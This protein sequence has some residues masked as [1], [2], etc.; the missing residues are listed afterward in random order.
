M[1]VSRDRKGISDSRFM[2]S[3]QQKGQ[4]FFVSETENPEESPEKELLDLF[5][6]MAVE[7]PPKP[8]ENQEEREKEYLSLFMAQAL[9]R[10]HPENDKMELTDDNQKLDIHFSKFITGPREGTEEPAL[11][12]I[13]TATVPTSGCSVHAAETTLLC[14]VLS[15][16]GEVISEGK[17]TPVR[18]YDCVWLDCNRPVQFR[19]YPNKPWE[20]A[21]LRVQGS[22]NPWVTPETYAY[23]YTS[24]GIFM[25]FGAGTRFRSIIWELLSQKTE[26]YPNSDLIYEHLLKGLFN[27]LN[28]V[29][30]T[31][32]T[33]Q[34]VIPDE[35]VAIQ[36]YLD[37]NYFEAISLDSISQKFNISKYYMSRKFK[38]YVG[39]SP[40]NYLIDLR[41]D[42]AKE[43]LADSDFTVAE[44]GRLVGIPNANHFLYLFKTRE[45]LTPSAF[46]KRRI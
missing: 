3:C 2:I 25:T 37:R 28:L 11:L 26:Q 33:R 32:S 30:I 8:A 7:Q 16:S 22:K 43:L 38:Q 10:D 17:G 5:I 27:E 19:A 44:I 35:I 46:R 9:E 45:G 36:N 1:P 18:K 6:S 42:K 29:L 20:C 23:L 14:Y 31:N 40:N 21:F 15:G 12:R 13:S 34:M 41:L 24:G 4:V 39:K